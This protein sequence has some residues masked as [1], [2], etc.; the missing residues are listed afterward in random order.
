MPKY[1][2]IVI[3]PLYITVD[4]DDEDQAVEKALAEAEDQDPKWEVSEVMEEASEED[5]EDEDV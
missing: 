3:K 1:K 2:V 4:A 5:E